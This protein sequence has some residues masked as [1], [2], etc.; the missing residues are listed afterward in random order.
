MKNNQTENDM[1]KIKKEKFK[2]AIIKQINKK[3]KKKYL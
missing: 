2:Q 1:K 3:L